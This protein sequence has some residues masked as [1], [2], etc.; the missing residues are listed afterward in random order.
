MDHQIQVDDQI[1]VSSE[2][3]GDTDLDS[4]RRRAPWTAIE[5]QAYVFP[6]GISLK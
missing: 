3:H 5:K 4:N 1:L 2:F 6:Y